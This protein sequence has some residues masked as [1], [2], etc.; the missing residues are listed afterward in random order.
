M[1]KASAKWHR[2]RCF[3]YAAL[4]MYIAGSIGAQGYVVEE[5]MGVFVKGTKATLLTWDEDSK[6]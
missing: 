5:A 6:F 3:G 2:V 4:S 1:V